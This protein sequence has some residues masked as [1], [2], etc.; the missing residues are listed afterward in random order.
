MATGFFGPVCVVQK[1]SP[2]NHPA[3]RQLV[4]NVTILLEEDGPL[5]ASAYCVEW[6]T[7][8]DRL[9]DASPTGRTIVFSGVHASQA[10]AADLMIW[11]IRR[12]IEIR[13]SIV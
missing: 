6:S 5:A 4:E 9:L 2:P 3:F 12:S 7:I 8:V 13:R 1:N 10:D 11:L